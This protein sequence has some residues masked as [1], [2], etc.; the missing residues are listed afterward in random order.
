[1]GNKNREREL[2]DTCEN[3]P[4]YIIIHRP[5]HGKQN[6]LESLMSRL[7]KNKSRDINIFSFEKKTDIEIILGM[8]EIES[9]I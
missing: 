5:P 1:M 3:H 7:M 2:Q 6:I 8:Y 9:L 4:Q